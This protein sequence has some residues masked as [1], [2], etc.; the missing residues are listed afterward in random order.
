MDFLG[1]VHFSYYKKMRV[2]TKQRMFRKLVDR[3]QPE[4]MQSYLGLLTHGDTF[5]I[6]NDLRNAYWLLGGDYD[7]NS[8]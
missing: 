8:T 6:E 1:W 3:P 5:K 7:L 2:K 4:V